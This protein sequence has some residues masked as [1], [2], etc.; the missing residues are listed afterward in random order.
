MKI[1]C[2]IRNVRTP[3][4]WRKLVEHQLSRFPDPMPI[5]SAKVAIAR[6]RQLRPGF[7]VQ[8]SLAVPG[9]DLHAEATGYTLQAAW[10]QVYKDLERQ[11]HGRAAKRLQRHK[12]HR[13]PFRLAP[14]WRA[15]A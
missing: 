10:L 15:R 12:A 13:Q 5:T 2:D 7:I 14:A 11:M 4:D 9:P 3:A 8:A 6:R 1:L